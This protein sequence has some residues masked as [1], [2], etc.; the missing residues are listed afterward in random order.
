M[1]LRIR[2]GTDAERMTK[3]FDQGELIWTTDT[4]KL[5]IGDS[6]PGT[7]DGMQGGVNI[8]TNSVLAGNGLSFNVEQDALQFNILEATNLKTQLVNETQ[9]TTYVNAGSVGQTLKVANSLGVVAGMTVF[10][11]A[12]LVG[13]VASVSLADSH[14]VTLNSSPAIELNNGDPLVF[15]SDNLYF[16][17]S[18]A[19]N[20]LN[21]ALIDGDQTGLSWT[22]TNTTISFTANVLPTYTTSQ[23]NAMTGMAEG[24][25]VFDSSTKYFK[26]WNGSNWVLIG[27]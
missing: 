6:T 27:G 9:A 12:D 7:T 2:R 26:G 1:S 10:Q 24:T 18:R 14:T 13:T 16:T 22:A 21:E 17:K 19:I 20:A 8:L 3:Y 23:I 25:M 5:Y 11:G 15:Q 4:N